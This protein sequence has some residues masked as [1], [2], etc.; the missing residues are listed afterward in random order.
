MFGENQAFF[1]KYPRTGDSVQ[2]VCHYYIPPY[3]H[4]GLPGGLMF[5]EKP[6]FS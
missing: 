2:A 3:I 6:S 1:W 4:K 5:G